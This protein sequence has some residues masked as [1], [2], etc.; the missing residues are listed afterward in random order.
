MTAD[1]ESHFPPTP[2]DDKFLSKIKLAL[3]NPDN[4]FYVDELLQLVDLHF[5][6]NGAPSVV[7]NYTVSTLTQLADASSDERHTPEEQV[8]LSCFAAEYVYETIR[9]TSRWFS[10]HPNYV[11]IRT[12]ADLKRIS[13]GT[14]LEMALLYALCLE[15]LELQVFLC[16]FPSSDDSD[17]HHALVAICHQSQTPDA[18][19]QSFTYIEVTCLTDGNDDNGRC[20]DFKDAVELGSLKAAGGQLIH[21]KVNTLLSD[22]RNFRYDDHGHAQNRAA[23]WIMWAQSAKETISKLR[24]VTL[25]LGGVAR[26]NSEEHAERE[27]YYDTISELAKNH[28]RPEIQLLW[29]CDTNEQDHDLLMRLRMLHERKEMGFD[30]RILRNDEFRLRF[31]VVDYRILVLNLPSSDDPDSPTDYSVRVDSR[32][33]ASHFISVFDQLWNDKSTQSFEEFAD[34]LIRALDPNREYTPVQLAQLHVL[35]KELVKSA[36]ERLT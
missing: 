26:T 7:K 23:M 34:R 36:Y 27:F 30:V 9:A 25:S 10:A 8:Q 17:P 28:P 31:Q 24:A 16:F 19:P 33:I 12:P 3:S 21:V 22:H 2:L 5:F 6:G 13:R 15:A 29:I 20:T 14:C 11:R 32:D 35:P 18:Q 4:F 1:F